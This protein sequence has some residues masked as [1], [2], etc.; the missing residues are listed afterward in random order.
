MIERHGF[1]W[2]RRHPDRAEFVPAEVASGRARRRIGP[3]RA[4]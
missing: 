2:T 3:G 1:S 4:I